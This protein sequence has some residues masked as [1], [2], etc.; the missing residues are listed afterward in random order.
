MC[1]SKNIELLRIP[2]YDW[3]IN[4]ESI[5]TQIKAFLNK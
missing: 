4:T 3:E 2:E 1:K 5:K